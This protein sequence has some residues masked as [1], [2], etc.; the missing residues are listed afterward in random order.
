MK[1]WISF[2]L[3]AFCLP[4]L[5][6]AV[7]QTSPS[8]YLGDLPKLQD[9]QTMRASS[10]DAN[11][12][13]GNA[14]ARPIPPGE[15][16]VVAEL[17]GP[18]VITHIWNTIA[19]KEKYY[20]RLLLLR[21]YWDGEE[22]PSVE[23]PIGDFFGIGH[24]LDEPFDSLPVRVSSDGRGRNCYWPMPFAKSARITVTNEGRQRTDAFYFYVDWEKLPKLDPEIAY[25]HAMYRQEFPAVMGKNYLIADIAGRGHY[26]GTVLSCRQ[27]TAS[28][29][30]E[31]DDFFFIDGETEPRLRGTGTEDYFC[32]GWGFRKQAGIY[33]GAP[34]VEG[35]S[36]GSR[37]TVYRWHIADPVHFRKSLRLEIEHKGV[38]FKPDGSVQSGFEERPDDF[39]SVAFW[40]QTEPHQPYPAMPAGAARLYYDLTNVVE[41]ESLIPQAKATEGTL[42]K[43]EIGGASGGA[44]LWWRPTAPDQTLTLPF[45]VKASGDYEILM[46]LTYSWDYGTYQFELDG[47]P[48]EKPLDFYHPSVEVREHLFGTQTLAAGPHTLTI[49]NQGKNQQSQGYF[50]GLDG[51]LLT[52]R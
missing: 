26:V 24:G 36:P 48:L 10:S 35:Y 9:A 37:S 52:K 41:G 34:L 31:G 18:G 32:D 4:L 49:R 11:W 25:F 7:A 50:F 21:M 42:E 16:L 27:L 46:F 2:V 33:Y 30:G 28:W 5:A 44:H 51:F 47:K 20:S 38:T 3:I 14:D 13:N 22:H 45:E 19:S 8:A 1:T 43:Q 39:S 40:Y 15:T 23:A 17:E 12:Q 29:W 6:T